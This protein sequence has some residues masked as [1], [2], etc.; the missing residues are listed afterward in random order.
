[1]MASFN[2]SDPLNGSSRTQIHMRAR[3][4]DQKK[5]PPIYFPNPT[6]LFC[7]FLLRGIGKLAKC[8]NYLIKLISGGLCCEL[9][10]SAVCAY[11]LALCWRFKGNVG[12]TIMKWSPLPSLINPPGRMKI[13]YNT[14]P[15]IIK[16]TQMIWCFMRG[17]GSH[18]G[19]PLAFQNWF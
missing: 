13:I 7:R 17:S 11:I 5:R 2:L 16:Y 10:V 19:A 18:P 3:S 4:A 8:M 9:Y 14:S 15:I 12:W 1:M 6:L